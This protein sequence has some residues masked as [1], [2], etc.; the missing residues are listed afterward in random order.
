MKSK[1]NRFFTPN[2]LSNNTT[3]DKFVLRESMKGY[4]DEQVWLTECGH[5]L[6][7]TYR[8]IS[9]TAVSIS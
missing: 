9:G 7:R 1:S 8:C 6:I 3:F 2:D 5:D 4:R